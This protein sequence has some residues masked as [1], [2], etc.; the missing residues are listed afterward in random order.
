MAEDAVC[1]ELVSVQIPGIR[2]FYREPI[3]FWSDSD[4]RLLKTRRFLWPSGRIP[5]AKEQG[6][7]S[8]VTGPKISEQGFEVKLKSLVSECPWL[9]M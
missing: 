9:R 7:K 1:C 4:V 8:P 6:L 2:D 3:I 5:Y